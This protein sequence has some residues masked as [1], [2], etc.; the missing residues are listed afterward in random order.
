MRGVSPI[1]THDGSPPSRAL[2]LP[3]DPHD[4][5][6]RTPRLGAFTTCHFGAYFSARRKMIDDHPKSCGLRKV[7]LP[8]SPRGRAPRLPCSGR[9]SHVNYVELTMYA[10]LWSWHGDWDNDCHNVGGDRKLE[11]EKQLQCSQSICNPYSSSAH[12]RRELFPNS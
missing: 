7:I 1:M 11:C 3:C 8:H 12:I 2:R 6:L 5:Q 10:P 9:Q 4:P